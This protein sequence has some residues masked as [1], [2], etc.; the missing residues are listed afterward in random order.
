M[1]ELWIDLGYGFIYFQTNANT[2]DDA[3]EDMSDKFHSIGIN[4]DNFGYY[5]ME[6]RKDFYKKDSNSHSNDYDVIET[7]KGH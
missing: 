3:L 4:D 1:N 7:R 2:I 5:E 6:L